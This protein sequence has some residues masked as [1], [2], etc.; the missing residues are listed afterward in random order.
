[1]APMTSHEWN[2]LC[3]YYTSTCFINLFVFLLLQY[4]DLKQDLEEE[5]P[6]QLE[7]TGEGTPGATGWLE[8]QIVGGKLLHSKKN[9]DGYV[10]SQAKLNK[11]MNGIRAAL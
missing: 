9:G 1:M 8:V 4:R 11:I 7:I 2:V 10:D 5:F 6:D 3:L